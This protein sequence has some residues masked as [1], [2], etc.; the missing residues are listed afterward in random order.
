MTKLEKL[1]AL[2]AQIDAIDNQM[3]DL[4]RARADIVHR[5]RG[6]K[7]KQ[8]IFI[9][10]GRE[11]TMLHALHRR[12]QGKIPPG[13]ITRLWREM[14]GA[15][16]M[17]EG[18]LR[19]AVTDGDS[20]TSPKTS[21]WDLTR[22][23]YGSVTPLHACATAAQ[24]LKTVLANKAE[25]AVVPL[26][27]TRNPWWTLL[28]KHPELRIFARLPYDLNDQPRNNGRGDQSGALAVARLDPE[29]TGNDHGLILIQVKAGRGKSQESAASLRAALKKAL[30]P[31]AI[32][33]EVGQEYWL[34]T[35]RG[36]IDREA[37]MGTA[38][39]YPGVT[40]HCCGGYAVPVALHPARSGH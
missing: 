2:R 25:V 28:A 7:G 5:V 20:K 33:G 23:F 18:A 10:P 16:T 24:A 12:R 32:A 3:H 22:D 8:A 21:L 27:T 38:Q 37:L 35:V 34:F 31:V 19:V 6:V 17:Q 13:L 9:R 4:L 26:L 15:F 29:P 11:A 39:N 40:L 30:N 14:I 36:L 1:Q